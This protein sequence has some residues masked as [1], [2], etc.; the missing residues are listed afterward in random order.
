M[1]KKPKFRPEITRIKLNPEQAVL[2]CGCYKD[3]VFDTIEG[4]DAGYHQIW[5]W[6]PA[7]PG[8]WVCVIGRTQFTIGSWQH[9]ACHIKSDLITFS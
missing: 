8:I 9:R 5:P 6:P 4:G 2:Q 3:G 1:S 7:D